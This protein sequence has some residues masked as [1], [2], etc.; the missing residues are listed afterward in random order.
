MAT[1]HEDAASGRWPLSR[2]ICYSAFLLGGVALAAAQLA[3]KPVVQV[4]QMPDAPQ[5]GAV[6]LILGSQN[7]PLSSGG[8]LRSSWSAQRERLKSR[9]AA[10]TVLVQEGGLNRWLQRHFRPESGGDAD[11][12]G[13]LAG[14]VTFTPPNV[15]FLDDGQVQLVTLLEMPWWEQ[16]RRRIVYQATYALDTESAPRLALTDARFGSTPTG[17]VPLLG[18]LFDRLL[19]LR[20]RQMDEGQW[21]TQELL[22]YW[23]EAERNEERYALTFEPIVATEPEPEL[24]EAVEPSE[25]EA[26]PEVLPEVA[27]AATDAPEAATD[28]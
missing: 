3:F 9:E 1:D 13:A 10:Q 15:R 20:F 6:Y 2:L 27:P 8:V 24:A 5:P 22:P 17:R 16:N 23:I 25:S 11:E 7:E 12:G 26:P 28:G 4:Q 18:Q 21:L 14:A 19:W